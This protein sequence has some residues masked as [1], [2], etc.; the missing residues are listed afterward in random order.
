MDILNSI[1]ILSEINATLP[2]TL[3]DVQSLHHTLTL[4]NPLTFQIFLSKRP[5]LD[6][7]ERNVYLE[8]IKRLKANEKFKYETAIASMVTASFPLTPSFPTKPDVYDA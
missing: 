2:V 8:I 7:V 4:E 1:P 3:K 6:E 5:D